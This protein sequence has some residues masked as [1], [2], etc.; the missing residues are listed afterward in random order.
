MSEC[1]CNL[2]PSGKMIRTSR[3]VITPFGGSLLKYT[4]SPFRSFASKSGRIA[5]PIDNGWR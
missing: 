2:L 4:L 1:H 5:C 3:L